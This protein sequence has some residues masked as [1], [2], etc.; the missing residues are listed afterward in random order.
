MKNLTKL[1]ASIALT[2]AMATSAV[3]GSPVPA[4][5]EAD[6]FVENPTP[7]LSPYAIAGLVAGAVLLAAV[8]ADDDDAVATTTAA[9]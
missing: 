1:V 7:G 4:V 3:A 8:L 9:E 2:A 5:V 6:V